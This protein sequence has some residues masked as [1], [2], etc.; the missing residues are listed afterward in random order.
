MTQPEPTDPDEQAF[1]DLHG[2][3]PARDEPPA[4]PIETIRVGGDLL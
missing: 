4:R 1:L 2:L 3:Q